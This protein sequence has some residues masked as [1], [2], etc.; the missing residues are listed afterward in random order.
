MISEH[1]KVQLDFNV[2]FLRS[3]NVCFLWFKL[4]HPSS[5]PPISTCLLFYFLFFLCFCV[6]YIFFIFTYTW[7]SKHLHKLGIHVFT[8]LSQYWKEYYLA[9]FV[10][11]ILINKNI[12]ITLITP[13]QF[14][15]LIL[16]KFYIFKNKEILCPKPEV[17]QFPPSKEKKV[18]K[19][20]YFPVLTCMLHWV[21]KEFYPL[22]YKS[23][24]FTKV[25]HIILQQKGDFYSS[26]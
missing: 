24:K 26:T 6:C 17:Q 3:N 18:L 15:I 1:S 19:T 22:F 5:P 2:A 21:H 20:N 14:P 12:V 7:Y 8:F 13:S 23:Q 16:V 11:K 9:N 4:S 10:I 25:Y